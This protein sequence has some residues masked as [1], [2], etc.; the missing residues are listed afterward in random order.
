MSVA[1]TRISPDPN[2]VLWEWR[3]LLIANGLSE[4]TIHDYW[5]GV[6]RLLEWAGIAEGNVPVSPLE[7]TQAHVV[8]FLASLG[9]RTSAKH[10]YA[11]GIRSLCAFTFASGYRDR[12]P[13][14]LVK[15]RQPRIP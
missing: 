13:C 11:K 14:S 2:A 12:D 6:Q 8:G 15:T 1:A 3:S 10:L 5:W 7:V 9:N 4:K